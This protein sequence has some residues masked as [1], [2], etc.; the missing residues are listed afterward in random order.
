MGD[1][2]GSPRVAPLFAPPS[3][4]PPTTVLRRGDAGASSHALASERR[5][6]SGEALPLA[7]RLFGGRE[8]EFGALCGLLAPVGLRTRRSS[9]PWSPRVALLTDGRREGPLR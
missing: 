7:D 1:L 8:N 2:L 9:L 4:R 6:A 3:P 5:R